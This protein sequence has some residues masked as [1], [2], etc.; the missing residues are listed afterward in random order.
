MGEAMP[1]R[2]LKAAIAVLQGGKVSDQKTADALV[3]VL[4]FENAA[5][6]IGKPISAYSPPPVGI[7][8]SPTRTPLTA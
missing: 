1:V 4:N 5:R 2:T 6:P 7:I 8:A 3:A